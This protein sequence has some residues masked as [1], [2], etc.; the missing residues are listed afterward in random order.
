MRLPK[1]CPASKQPACTA[2]KP[3]RCLCCLLFKPVSCRLSALSTPLSTSSVVYDALG[4]LQS[5]TNGLGTF[6][7]GYVNATGRLSHLDYPNGQRT[8]Y[9]YYPNIAPGGTGNG[10]QRLQRIEN[11]STSALR[12]QLTRTL[13]ILRARS[14]P[15]AARMTPPPL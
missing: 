4:R 2:S 1:L 6:N 11:L 15:G 7:Y 13:T 3:L 8:N 10:D 14:K 9:S 5:T 12:F